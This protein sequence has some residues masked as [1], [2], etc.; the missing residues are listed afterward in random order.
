MLIILP[1]MFFLSLIVGQSRAAVG[2]GFA[3]ATILIFLLSKTK[4]IKWSA[5]MLL[6]LITIT[7]IFMDVGVVQKG[8]DTYKR[9]DV[10][11]S[12][13]KVWNISLEAMRF[14]PLLGI[15]LSNWGEIKPEDI[16][17]SVEARGETYLE[18]N[19]M[20]AG[21]SHS[22]YLTTIVER[23][24][25]GS[26][27]MLIF[28]IAWMIHLIKNFKF[29]RNNIEASCLWGASLSAWLVSFGIG[30]VNTTMHHEHGILAF[31]FLALFLNYTKRL[32]Q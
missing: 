3:T 32:R 21:H 9:N 13:D 17:R 22:L 11:A 12:R 27:V 5:M 2:V 30:T 20:F 4:G 6:I 28:M 19:Y 23:G 1:I 25:I 29:T 24:I 15:G 26:F 8:R 14:S 18:S 31:L 16:K 7:T 10:L